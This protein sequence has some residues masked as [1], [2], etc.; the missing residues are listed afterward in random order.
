LPAMAFGMIALE[1]QSRSRVAA[2][3]RVRGKF[4]RPDHLFLL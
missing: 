4:T 3:S 2:V 1:P